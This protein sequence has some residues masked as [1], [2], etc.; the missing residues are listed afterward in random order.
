MGS[1]S[2]TNASPAEEDEGGAAGVVG[3]AGGSAE[4]PVSSCLDV[5]SGPN[6]EEGHSSMLRVLE[7]VAAFGFDVDGVFFRSRRIVVGG[8]RNGDGRAA[9][10]QSG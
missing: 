4:E 7:V 2:P 10:G 9:A 3:V 1:V 6:D 5:R 8:G